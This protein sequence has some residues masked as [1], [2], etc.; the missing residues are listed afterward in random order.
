[1]RSSHLLASLSIPILATATPTLAQQPLVLDD[2]LVS[3]GRTP[4]G[5]TETGRS[6][7]VLTGKQLEERGIR[8]LGDALRF[9]PGVAVSRS[10]GV[11]G[12]TQIRIRGAENNQV[13]VLIDGVEVAPANNG[14]L[15]LGSIQITDIER[16]EVIRGPQ[17]ALYGSNA[18]AGVISI[19]TRRGRRNDVEVGA[20]TEGGSDGT[21]LVSGYVAGGGA[22]W[23]GSVSTSFRRTEG[24]NIATGTD[25][26]EGE[27]DGDRNLTFNAKGNADLTDAL[28]VGGVFRVVS[29]DSEFDAQN[30]PFPPDATSGLVTD[31]DNVTDATDLSLAAFGQYA[32]LDDALTHT[33]RFEYSDNILDSLVNGVSTFTQESQRFHGSAQSSLDFVAGPTVNLVTAAFELEEEQNEATTGEQTRTLV[34]LIGEYQGNLFDIVDLQAGIR[35]DFNDAFEDAFTYSLS[36]SYFLTETGTRFHSSVGRGV[37]NPTFT[38]QFGFFPGSFAGNPDLEPEST[39]QWDFGVEQRFFAERLIVDATYFRG[40]V[41]DEIVD[42]FDTAA[43]LPTSVNATGES[44]R[45]G[46]ELQVTATPLDRLS[47]IA[48]YTYILAEEGATDLQE[49]RRPRHSGSF[50]ALYAFLDNRATVNLGIVYSGDSRDLDFTAGTFPAP[51]TVLDDYILVSLQGNYRMTE[52]VEVFARV[53]NLTDTDYQEVQSFETQGIAGFGGVRVRF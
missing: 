48:N 21:T 47:L 15:D 14:E 46:V 44:P 43:N 30:F 17:S 34:G 11:G 42:G 24:F 27:R 32:M 53:E 38:E 22:D 3:G 10:G 13:L 39:F 51:Q 16:I 9:V 7:T 23:D 1:M 35:Y 18:A 40:H 49:V 12:L 52:Q 29:R 26:D 6:F 45:Q 37:V 19:I 36:A 28:S 4:V 50:N 41:T 33:L 5:T 25:D 20:T 8:Y 2:I 31:S